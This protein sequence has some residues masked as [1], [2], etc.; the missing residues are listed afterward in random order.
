[1]KLRP[2]FIMIILSTITKTCIRRK[3]RTQK[4]NSSYDTVLTPQLLQ[5]QKLRE[6]TKTE[7]ETYCGTFFLLFVHLSWLYMIF[8]GDTCTFFNNNVINLNK[9]ERLQGLTRWHLYFF[10][11]KL[12]FVIIHEWN[13]IFP[14]FSDQII[15]SV[16]I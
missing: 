8:L 11:P 15:T 12:T 4:M 13:S 7:T 5:L 9:G 3:K 6:V 16:E 2:R 14:L 1:M 10:C